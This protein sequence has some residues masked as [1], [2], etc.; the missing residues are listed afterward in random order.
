MDDPAVHGAAQDRALGLQRRGVAE[1][2]PQAQ[3]DGGE[4]DP[5]AAGAAV[6][7]RGIA[8]FGGEV[9]HAGAPGRCGDVRKCSGL[10]GYPWRFCRVTRV[11]GRP[12]RCPW[13]RSRR[14]ADT[15]VTRGRRRLRVWPGVEGVGCAGR[16][17]R[18]PSRAARPAA[19]PSAGWSAPPGSPL[20]RPGRTRC[21]RASSTSP[22][23]GRK[24]AAAPPVRPAVSAA[25]SSVASTV[26]RCSR[27]RYRR[28]ATPSGIDGCRSS[29]APLD[30]TTCAGS[31]KPS[32]KAGWD[33]P[34]HALSGIKGRKRTYASTV[35]A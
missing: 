21:P 31:M 14:P 27:P 22:R 26:Q 29:V 8:V 28:A 4:Q 6:L 1:V 11:P 32:W 35:H 19:C 15:A 7:H 17:G 2:V 5:A 9:G 20:T 12:A 34:C 3:G 30:T 10:G 23:V 13:P 16:G 24:T 18:P 33:A 25:G